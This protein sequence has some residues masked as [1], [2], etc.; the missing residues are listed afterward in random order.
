M[1]DVMHE[2]NERANLAGTNRLE[3][4]MFMLNQQEGEESQLFGI[5]VFKVKELLAV[6]P[7]RTIPMPAK[8]LKGLANIRGES[9]PVI[10]LMEYCGFQTETPANILILTEYN[11]S[12]QGFLVHNVDNIA[13]FAWSDVR[14]P[15]QIFMGINSSVVTG[16]SE[17]ND[18][19]LLLILDIEKIL[20]DVL[21]PIEEKEG[22]TIDMASEG[23]LEGKTVFF[24]DDSIVARKQLE[25]VLSHMGAEMIVSTDGGQAWEKLQQIANQ[26]D[27][28]ERPIRGLKSNGTKT[29]VKLNL[30]VQ[31][32]VSGA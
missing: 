28:D 14:E 4:L 12:S 31:T 8:Y 26:A 9:V 1:H 16:I 10:D 29:P 15:P 19:K 20:S 3:V 2:M 21:G 13:R 17:I 22:N 18:Q 27:A 24:V 6:P 25:E 23:S 30:P 32:V 11:N 7:L 5:N